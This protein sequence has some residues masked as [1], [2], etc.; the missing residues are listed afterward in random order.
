MHRSLLSLVTVCTVLGTLVF[1]LTGCGGGDSSQALGEAYVA[2]A[3]LNLRRELNQKNTVATLKHGD[4][5]AIVDTRRR[6][7]KV[8]TAKGEEG[9]VD[10]LQLL[11]QEQMDRVRQDARK[12][13]ALPSEGSATVFEALNIHIDPSRQ[14]P[15]FA[16]IPETGSVSILAHRV[17]PKT[18]APPR[19]A[20]LVAERPAPVSRRQR[21]DRQS[22]TN[23]RLPPAPPPPKAPDNLQELSPQPI[24]GAEA[25]VLLKPDRDKE[26]AAKK[27]VELSKPVVL[28]DWSLVRTKNNECGWVLSR[29][30][31]MSIPDEVA[32][33]A[34]GKRIT[35]YF[36]LGAVT[37]EEK[38]LKH[39]WLWTTSSATEPYD[40]DSWRVFLWNR[41]RH[42]YETSYR[43]HDVEGYFPVHVDP[44][45]SNAFGR[46][47]ELITKDDDGKFRRR[48]YLFDGTRV[49]LTGTEFYRPGEV[50]AGSKPG[51]LD[52]AKLQE[53]MPK[54]GWLRREWKSL[55]TRLFGSA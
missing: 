29:N 13:L 40:F 52:T 33:Y 21:K 9:W 22:K 34:E 35:S 24:N 44:S 3:S 6:F 11:S 47:F 7:V 32:Q 45:D 42:R 54:D 4:R 25:P 43:Q 19:P 48:T 18:T 41:R 5:V 36:D 49:H 46:T 20:S 26:A 14:S 53:K 39:N 2:P 10:S 55:K 16:R 12:A 1:G 38:G 50:T 37:D 51:G 23:W 28:E 15:A 30:L 27:A 8:R 31:V 17:E